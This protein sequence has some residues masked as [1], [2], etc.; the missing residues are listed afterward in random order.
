MPVHRRSIAE[1]HARRENWASQR[2]TADS[3][4][5]YLQAE[6]A[7]RRHT[8]MVPPQKLHHIPDPCGTGASFNTHKTAIRVAV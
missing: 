7:S 8:D 3:L 4:G 5:E 1:L 2:R 6:V